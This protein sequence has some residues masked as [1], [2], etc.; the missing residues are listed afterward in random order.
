VSEAWRDRP[1]LMKPYALADV[2]DFLLG[3]L[4]AVRP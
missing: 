1:F 4:P 3:N 2:R